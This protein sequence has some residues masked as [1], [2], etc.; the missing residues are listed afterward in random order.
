MLKNFISS[1]I[2]VRVSTFPLPCIS[3]CA[4]VLEF[5]FEITMCLSVEDFSQFVAFFQIIVVVNL[6]FIT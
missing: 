4:C 2:L 3:V 1:A 5:G 6:N